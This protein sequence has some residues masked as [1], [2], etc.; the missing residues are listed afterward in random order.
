MTFMK[1]SIVA[2]LL[3]AV[4]ANVVSASDTDDQDHRELYDMSCRKVCRNISQI[5]KRRACYNQCTKEIEEQKRTTDVPCMELCQ[6]K[7][8]AEICLVQCISRQ[9]GDRNLRGIAGMMD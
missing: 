4:V 7:P 8:N 2:L 5:G 9:G 3:F 1:K 6:G